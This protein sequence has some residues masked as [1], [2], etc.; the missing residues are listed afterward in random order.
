[1]CALL[2]S[3]A[4]LAGV[5]TAVL[6]AP[7]PVLA[8]TG[9]PDQPP[10]PPAQPQDEGTPFPPALRGRNQI[11]VTWLMLFDTGPRLEAVGEDAVKVGGGL[12]WG[13]ASHG[14]EVFYARRLPFAPDLSVTLEL[15]VAYVPRVRQAAGSEIF[16]ETGDSLGPAPDFEVIYFTPRIN[17][18]LRFAP[19]AEGTA[20]AWRS[21]EVSS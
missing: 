19:P 3:R 17:F 10:S 11:G 6:A 8:Q 7:V 4:F 20:T 9:A 18:A 5:M 15:P 14:V 1:M 16:D 12:Q 13:A 2:L 21:S